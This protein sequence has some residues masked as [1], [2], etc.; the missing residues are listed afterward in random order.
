MGERRRAYTGM[1]I[2]VYDTRARICRQTHEQRRFDEALPRPVV[3][4]YNTFLLL[5]FFPSLPALCARFPSEKVVHTRERDIDEG[6]R[7]S[8]FFFLLACVPNT[9][10]NLTTE[11]CK[12]S[13]ISTAYFSHRFCSDSTFREPK[14]IGF[15]FRPTI[16][17]FISVF[18]EWKITR[19]GCRRRSHSRWSFYGCV[20]DG[21]RLA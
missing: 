5:P 9:L 12:S 6:K 13:Y 8:E 14:P 20:L 7:G 3:L 4:V 15:F 18:I 19:N 1:E 11:Q 2:D 21:L 10:P 16:F 17:A